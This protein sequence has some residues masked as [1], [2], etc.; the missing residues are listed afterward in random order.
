MYTYPPDWV[1]DVVKVLVSPDVAMTTDPPLWTTSVNDSLPMVRLDQV[2]TFV[3][4]E[5]EGEVAVQVRV[6]LF[7]GGISITLIQAGVMDTL[8]LGAVN[9]QGE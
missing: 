8:K 2:N 5:P 9:N 4:A 3:P 7:Q 1:S 6:K